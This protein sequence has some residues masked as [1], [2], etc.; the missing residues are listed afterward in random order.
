MV[1]RR[2]RGGRRRAD[3]H[4]V[5]D[6]LL[7]AISAPRP[8]ASLAFENYARGPHLRPLRRPDAVADRSRRLLR[9][10]GVGALIQLASMVL[11]RDAAPAFAGLA[12]HA[13]CAQAIAG[14]LALLPLHRARRPVLCAARP[15]RGG[16]HDPDGL[17]VRRRGGCRSAGGGR[18]GGAGT[19]AP[20]D[21]CRWR[22]ALAEGAAGRPSCRW[23]RRR[24]A[25]A[26][27]AAAGGCIDGTG[28]PA[29]VAAALAD[30]QAG[31]P[32]LVSS[33]IRRRGPGPRRGR[34][35][36]GSRPAPGR[37]APSC[38]RAS[39]PCRAGACPRTAAPRSA[40]TGRN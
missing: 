25:G 18:N 3:G 38:G 32:R 9:R 17:P 13:G 12:G 16:R 4:P 35:R 10:D 15:A 20:A 34:A 2:D 11:D 22:S 27:R 28:A 1:A 7:A 14:L 37:S 8:A 24:A 31:E 19:P 6:A 40:G 33:A 21:L 30:G 23:R 36:S 26:D 39:C 5:A 29:G